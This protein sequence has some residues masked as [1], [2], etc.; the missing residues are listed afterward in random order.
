[1]WFLGSS[2]GGGGRGE[3]GGIRGLASVNRNTC[4]VEAGEIRLGPAVAVLAVG[5]INSR[6][7]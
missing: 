6:I 7:C 4:G 3:F 1:M 5:F 2:C